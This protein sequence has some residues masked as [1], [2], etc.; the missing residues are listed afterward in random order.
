LAV[1]SLFVL[2]I[3]RLLE[4]KGE[5]APAIESA[6]FIIIIAYGI[7][8]F[9]HDQVSIFLLFFFWLA[10]STILFLIV[11]RICNWRANYGSRWDLVSLSVGFF[12][13]SG[14]IFLGQLG[15]CFSYWHQAP[16]SI[17]PPLK[18][19]S[20]FV[21]QGGSSALLNHHRTTR[22][23]TAQR[24]AVDITKLSSLGRRTSVVLPARALSD[25]II[26]D[27]PVYSP[28]SGIILF[29]EDDIDDEPIGRVNED[30]PAGNYLAIGCNSGN[31]I[32][33][34][35]LRR[36][37]SV[38]RGSSV[39]S[40]QRIGSVGNSGNSTEP[41]LHLHAISGIAKSE[42]DAL[43]FGNGIGVAINEICL[44]RNRILNLSKEK[45]HVR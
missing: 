25:Y 14:L 6:F 43:F 19:G 4:E 21:V 42:R 39:V 5:G 37:I 34:A 36:G 22:R 10:L 41:H 12:G 30:K 27:E 35:H 28:C 38:E 31:T 3:W 17:D 2:C 23:A 18:S 1:L 24:Y 33:L 11:L 8:V 44:Y 29:K 40:G 15:C 32:V 16:L 7:V 20:F 13:V 26:F 9:R 45:V